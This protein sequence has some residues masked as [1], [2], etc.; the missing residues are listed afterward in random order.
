MN[1]PKSVP[2]SEP[3]AAQE[4][5]QKTTRRKVLKVAAVAAAGVAV[6]VAAPAAL[7]RVLFRGQPP[8]WRFLTDAEASL[9]DAMCAQIIPTD[10]DPGRGRQAASSI[11]T[12]NWPGRTSGLPSAIGRGLP[13]WRPLARPCMQNPSKSFPPRSRSS[14][15]RN[16][17]GGR[18]QGALEDR[19]LRRILPVGLRSL[20]A[21]LLR[22]PAS[23]RQQGLCQLP[24]AR[25][26]LPQHYRTEPLRPFVER[27]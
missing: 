2:P 12:G 20:D 19:L 24:H 22:Q 14:C 17:S 16:W 21:G 27:D 13:R 5:P 26:G 18:R 6:G 3:A 25:P 15:W 7:N 10:Q 23:R 4:P 1:E 11:S 9:L 8:R